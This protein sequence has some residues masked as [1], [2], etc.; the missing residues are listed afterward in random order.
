MPKILGQI[1][2]D[3]IPSKHQWK[4]KLFNNW[5]DIM[6]NLKEKAKIVQ[7]TNNSI[8]LG[9][10]HPTWAQE[11]R[12]LSSMIKK[13][14]NNLFDEEKIKK[15]NFK[16]INFSN[17]KKISKNVEYRCNI[18]KIEY[19][20]SIEEHNKLKNIKNKELASS[21]EKFYVRCKVIGERKREKISKNNSS[22][23]TI[24]SNKS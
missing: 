13:K 21:L 23:H 7:I 16:V 5:E 22:Y 24:N 11:L 2:V 12:L 17:K 19:L 18:E 15:I 1:L 4:I 6:G 14:I 9:V 3:I 10:C 20:L 8:T